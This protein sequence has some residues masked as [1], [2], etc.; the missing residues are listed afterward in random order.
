[1]EATALAIFVAKQGWKSFW[2]IAPDFEYGRSFLNVFLS[3]IKQLVPDM[4]LVGQSWPRLGETDF[5]AYISYVTA[6]KP[7]FLMCLLYGADQIS[8]FKQA[9]PY[10]LFEKIHVGGIFDLSPLR[11]LGDE[12]V[13]GV[14]GFN[15]ADFY[16]VNSPEMKTFVERFG[17]AFGGEYPTKYSISGYDSVTWIKQAIEKTKSANKEKLIDSLEGT[18]F[19]SPRGKVLIRAYDHQANGSVYVGFTTKRPEYPFYVYK[20][21]L[22][23]PGEQTW[24]PV[25]EVK[26]LR[27]GK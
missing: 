17:K 24:L 1:M 23:V 18:E 25:E 12:M 3:K 5:T 9:K 19:S 8:F 21:V 4:K 10:G 20:D 7:D 2:T 11:A 15:I 27:T 26:K 22:E 13:E 6:A 16:C 14:I